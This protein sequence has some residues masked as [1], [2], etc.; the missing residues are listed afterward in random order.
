M[1][2]NILKTHTQTNYTH[3]HIPI[4]FIYLFIRKSKIIQNINSDGAKIQSSI[5]LK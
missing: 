5:S 4:L 2:K 1:G 3:I